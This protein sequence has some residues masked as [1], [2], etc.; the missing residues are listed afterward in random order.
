MTHIV[1]FTGPMY[2]GK[3]TAC[4]HLRDVLADHGL[5]VER[6]GFADA[7]KTSAARALGAPTEWN[8]EECIA[9]CDRLKE[10][11]II[12]VHFDER[13]EEFDGAGAAY[14][15]REVFTGSGLTGRRYLQVYGTESHRDVFGQDF[16]VDA[17]L[18]TPDEPG[19]EFEDDGVDVLAISDVRFPNEAQ[20]IRDLGGSVVRLVR[21]ERPEAQA[22]PAHA[23]EAGVSD[24][25]ITH[26]IQNNGATPDTLRPAI[27]ALARELD[28]IE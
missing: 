11:G 7:L 22:G 23:S 15:H 3:D 18:P 2:S 13:Y 20:R 17:L 14:S 8:A 10:S 12:H 9:F 4:A 5:V 6:Q 27:E 26:E 21:G 19:Q 28:L 16:W 1:G 25:L 24:D